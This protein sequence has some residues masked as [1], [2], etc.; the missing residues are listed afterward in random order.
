MCA[1]A[2]LINI[3]MTQSSQAFLYIGHDII[4][5]MQCIKNYWAEFNQLLQRWLAI[6][7]YVALVMHA[8]HA[9]DIGSPPDFLNYA[10]NIV[11]IEAMWAGEHIMGKEGFVYNH[12]SVMAIA[13]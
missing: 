8:L 5:C 7:S 1:H 2:I 9:L 6:N 13:T 4:M 11:A 12:L 3:V 10:L